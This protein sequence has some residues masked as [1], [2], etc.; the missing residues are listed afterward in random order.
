MSNPRDIVIGI[1]GGGSTTRAIASDLHGN[2]LGHAQGGSSFAAKDPAATLNVQQT[3]NTALAMANRQPSDI[4]SLVAGVAGYDRKSDLIWVEKL[5]AVPGILCQRFHVNDA[6]VAHSGAFVAETGIVI[7]AGSGCII[8]GI[9]PGGRQIRN[10]DF[11]HYAPAAAR[12]LGLEAMH[13]LLAGNLDPSDENLTRQIL[14]HWQAPTL[15]KF[16]ETGS[17]GFVANPI[18]RDN[19]LST[20]APTI[21]AAAGD[22][23]RLAQRV[24]DRAIFQI[25][26][27]VQL[28]SPLFATQPVSTALVGSVANSDYFKKNLSQRLREANCNVIEPRLSPTAGAVLLA[29]RQLNVPIDEQ[30]INNLQHKAG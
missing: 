26:I 6:L 20:L 2:V 9:T 30:V 4:K 25:V 19:K 21:T 22:G 29:L 28:L 3:I 11:L 5:T 8:F 17:A 16:R 15:E 24:C 7:I 14:Q 23:S 1:D 12:F 13:E 27:G 10:Y 18:E